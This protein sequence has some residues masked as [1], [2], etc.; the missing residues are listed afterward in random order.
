MAQNK[1]QMAH[2]KEKTDFSDLVDE[3][4]TDERCL[5]MKQ[6]TQHG[7]VSTYDHCMN[8]ARTSYRLG[9]L[10]RLRL[11]EKELVRG[12]FLHDYFLYDWHH[13]DGRWHGFTHSDSAA[14]NAAEDFDISPRE[15]NIIKSHM[16]PL[17]L[18]HLPRSREAAIVCI[19][20]KLCSAKETLFQRG[21][22]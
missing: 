10:L 6:Y 16:W 5:R 21:K 20:D 18:R 1:G 3:I 7:N 13:H 11:N 22:H 9:K 14:R 8:V 15:E 19:A 12:A 17:T 2:S 4:S